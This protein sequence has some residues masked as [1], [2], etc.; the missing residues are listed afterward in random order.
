MHQARTLVQQQRRLI[1]A[2]AVRHKVA[3]M[4]QQQLRQQLMGARIC[5]KHLQQ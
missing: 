4:R 5:F 1:P 2:A 3:Q